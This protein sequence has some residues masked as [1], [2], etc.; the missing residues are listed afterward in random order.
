VSQPSFD[1][2]PVTQ[3]KPGTGAGKSIEVD[4]TPLVKAWLSGTPNNGLL[5]KASGTLSGGTPESVYGFYSREF[6]DVEKR[7]VLILSAY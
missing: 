4:I 2:N 7:P 5:L 3:F 1:P 6:A